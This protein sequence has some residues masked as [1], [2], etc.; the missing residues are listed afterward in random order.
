MPEPPYELQL[1]FGLSSPLADWDNGVKPFQDVLQK[2]F[3]FNDKDIVR[4]VVE[5]VLV[6]KGEEYISFSINTAA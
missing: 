4:A 1:R 5:K 2:K 6:K 3:G